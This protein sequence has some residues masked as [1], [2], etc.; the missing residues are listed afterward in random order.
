MSAAQNNS[1]E[2]IEQQLDE[3]A[4]ELETV[5]DSD[6]VTFIGPI[7]GGIEEIIRTTMEDREDKREKLIFVLETPGGSIEVV[8]RIVD[9]LRH[10]YG[11]VEFIVPD[12]AMSA[13]TVL[14]MSGDAF[15]MDY[16]SILGPIDPQ[17]Q[18][19]G[20]RG[21]VP[22]LGYLVQYERLIEKS[23]KGKLT[24]AELTYMIEKF[25]PAELY[26]YEQARELS[27]A[28]LEEWLIKY[29]F[30]N[31][32]KTET[33]GKKVTPAKKKMRAIRI[34]KKLNDTERWHSHGR[35]ISMD[36]LR[37]DIELKVEDFGQNPPM[38]AAIKSY[39]TLMGDYMTR[40]GHT[41]VTHS[42][43]RYVGMKV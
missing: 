10:H 43:G 23:A 13:G 5:T 11:I 22:A 41:I 1:N 21:Y 26:L 16:F 12:Y 27:I 20:G 38:N 40:R 17:V 24:T 32:V 4:T 30:K 29:K 35:G 37:K 8:R 31:W 9:T 19:A 34:A 14:V 33:H 2:I 6:V 15:Y 25:D 3:K 18:K 7:W 42:I 39:Y 28:L 36:V